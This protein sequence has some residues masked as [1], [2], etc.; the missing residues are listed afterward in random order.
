MPPILIK[1]VGE[2]GVAD[3]LGPLI[4]CP[5]LSPFLYD[6][7]CFVYISQPVILLDCSTL[8]PHYDGPCPI[9]S[10]TKSSNFGQKKIVNI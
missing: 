7:S 8:M 2:G 3:V 4:I 1:T 9:N 10:R 6:F 5:H